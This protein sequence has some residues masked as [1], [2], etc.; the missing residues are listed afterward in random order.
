MNPSD[1]VVNSTRSGV[2]KTTVPGVAVSTVSG[3]ADSTT[4]TDHLT[5]HNNR[6]VE[7]VDVVVVNDN[8]DEYQLSVE[9]KNKFDKLF[10]T[11]AK[12]GESKSSAQSAF[13]R[14][15]SKEDSAIMK[16]IDTGL[17][18][19]STTYMTTQMK[20]LVEEY[21]NIQEAKANAIKSKKNQ[22]DWNKAHPEQ[23]M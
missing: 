16:Y 17:D 20:V 15:T 1:G 18:A 21:N 3:V 2:V 4:L 10:S 7:Q 6:P 11:H 14:Y 5:D 9:E 19:T 22:D 13:I 23:Q 8:N 12:R